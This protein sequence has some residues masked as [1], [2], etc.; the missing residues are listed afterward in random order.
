M[1]QPVQEAKDDLRDKIARAPDDPTSPNYAF[2]LKVEG[3]KDS[4]VLPF[5]GLRA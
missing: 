3:E 4:P 5:T 1:H 2:Y